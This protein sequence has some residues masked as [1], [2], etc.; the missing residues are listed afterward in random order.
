M[1]PV[2]F[3]S[4]FLTLRFISLHLGYVMLARIESAGNLFAAQTNGDDLKFHESRLLALL[5]C[6]SSRPQVLS[7]LSPQHPARSVA[8][9]SLPS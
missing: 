2:P 5:L 3:C 4:I 1:V 6:F 8:C 7:L 9:S